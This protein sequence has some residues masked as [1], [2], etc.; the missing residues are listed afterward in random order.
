MLSFPSGRIFAGRARVF[1]NALSVVGRPGAQ[2]SY[3]VVRAQ[4]GSPTQ[5]NQISEQAAMSFEPN[6][7]LVPVG[8]G[9]PIPLIRETLVIG[10][11]ES[12]DV[13]LHYPNVSSKHCE[14]TFKDG[15]WYIRDLNSTNGIKVNGM[16]VQ[17]KLLHPKDEISIAKRKFIIDYQL[18]GGKR[19]LEE[20]EEDVLGQSLLEK[21][22]LERPL[23]PGEKRPGKNFD[24]ADFL[25][26]EDE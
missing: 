21:A 26:D 15:Y 20:I 17:Q 11:R 23:A 18:T 12:C 6:G 2:L 8:G 25:L 22:G 24:P 9:D 16:R 13:C 19:A 10:R 4:A 3:L 14:L 1:Y 5:R 7:E